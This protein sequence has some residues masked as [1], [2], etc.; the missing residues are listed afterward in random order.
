MYEIVKSVIYA[1]DYKLADIQHK[2]KKLFVM[3]DLTEEQ[4]DELFA[5]A[6]G[7]VSVDAERPETLKLIQTLADEIETLKERV[8]ALEGDNG[9][10]QPEHPA[11]KA[12]DGISK[13]YQKGAIVSHNGELW[14]SVFN[15]QNVWMPG[16][17]GTESLWVKYTA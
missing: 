3:G 13:D 11:W 16:A 7:G 8:T 6:S 2:V 12:W 5:M 1:G 15:G 14:Q 9:E 4:A 17:P 10:D